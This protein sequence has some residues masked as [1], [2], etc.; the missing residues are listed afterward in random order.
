MVWKSTIHDME[1]RLS[2]L[3]GDASE[4][5]EKLEILAREKKEFLSIFNSLDVGISVS[6]PVTYEILYANPTVR[7]AYGDQEI[8]GQK[9]HKIFQDH[10]EP[11]DFCTNLI[12]FGKG[13]GQ[14]YIYDFKNRL[15]GKWFHCIDKAIQWPDGRWVRWAMAI[16][17]DVQK[18]A[19]QDLLE[20]KTNLERL[21]KIDDRMTSLGRVAAGMAHEIRSPLSGINL[22]LDNLM[23]MCCSPNHRKVELDN[24]DE[25]KLII[26]MALTASQKIEEVVKRVLDFSRPV[27]VKWI[28]TNINEPIQ[29]AVR[30]SDVTLRKEGIQIDT[31]FSSDCPPCYVDPGLIQQVIMGLITNAIEVMENLGRTKK[32]EIRSFKEGNN[33]LIRVSDSGPGVPEEI[34]DKIFEPFFTTKPYGSGIGLSICHR[35]VTDH[36]GLLEVS[37]SKLKGA[38]FSI[39]IPVSSSQEN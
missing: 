39:K 16:N 24:F 5:Q 10:D 4:Y 26:E 13:K 33:V 32:I 3:E 29:D 30:L 21:L 19:E 20:S 27:E 36:Q 2:L 14:P 11:C 17:I 12:I 28:L 8:L 34:R 18:R 9:C 31:D 22:L 23:N 38:E 15:N 35:I 1:Q 7:K 25:I 37:S 6:D